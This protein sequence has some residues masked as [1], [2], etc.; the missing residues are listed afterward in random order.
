MEDERRIVIRVVTESHDGLPGEATFVITSKRPPRWAMTPEGSSEDSID[1]E[2]DTS[3]FTG[4]PV[5]LADHLDDVGEAAHELA[6]ACGLSPAL[7]ADLALAGRLHDLGKADSRFQTMLR[8]GRITAEGLLAKSDL[9]EGEYAARERARRESGYP[10]G[11]RHELLSV[12][13]AEGSSAIAATAGDWELVLHLVASHHGYC[14]PFAPV[15]RDPS[16][17][18]V[19]AEFDGLRLEHTSATEMARID[20][21]VADRFWRLVSRYGWFGLAWLETL[22]RLADHRVSAG[23]KVGPRTAEVGR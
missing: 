8:N 23:A 9:T 5:P 16:P 18:H 6:E 13:L 19:V 2:P 12:A 1:S 3:S 11:G 22:L 20:S 21:R 14:R 7:A 15:V 4:R 17:V 10:A